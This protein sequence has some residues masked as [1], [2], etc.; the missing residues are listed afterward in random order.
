MPPSASPSF[1]PAQSARALDSVV[2]QVESAIVTGTLAA[3]DRL[4]AERRLQE[5]FG[6]SR[7]TLREALRALEQKGLLEIRPGQKGG[8]F[9]KP[10]GADPMADHL[11]MFVASRQVTL[12][13][14]AE[15]RMDIEGLLARRAAERCNAASIA[16]LESLV[17]EAGALHAEGLDAWD[18]FMAADRQIHLAVADAAGNPLHSLFLQTVHENIH[19]HNI[20]R[21]LNRSLDYMTGC[22]DDLTRMV[23]AIV[24]GDGPAARNIAEAHVARAYAD[25]QR[26]AFPAGGALQ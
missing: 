11:A 24:N 22:L 12:A 16:G 2:Q 15:F 1:Q 17:R 4:P 9:V 26:R 3:G 7:N 8:A 21:Y 13:H 18:R 5:M 23:E 10:L 19:R 14:M 25:M 20:G 6:I